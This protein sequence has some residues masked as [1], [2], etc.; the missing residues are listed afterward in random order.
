[1]RDILCRGI[2]TFMLIGFLLAVQFLT[3]V[4]IRRDLGNGGPPQMERSLPWFPIIGV[5][6]GGVLASIDVLLG[7]VFASSVRAALVLTASALLTGMLHLDGFIDCC[8]GLLGVRSVERRLDIMRDSRVG[9]YGA[10][11]GILLLVLKFAALTALPPALRAFGLIVSPL[12]G[13]WSMVYAVVRYPYARASGAGSAFASRPRHLLAA[14]LSM[15][16]ALALVCIITRQTVLS[17]LALVL[18]AALVTIAWTAW[19]NRRL[20]GGLTGDTY[21]ASNELIELAV[22]LLLPVFARLAGS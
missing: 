9:A 20:A 13:R 7:A 6:I 14:T 22:L 16:I 5:L 1:M 10:I 2:L 12:L 18:L 4:P 3:A 21:G 19:A 15:G 17:A 11:G 8:D